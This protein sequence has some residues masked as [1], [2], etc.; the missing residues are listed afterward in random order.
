M[1]VWVPESVFGEV[2]LRRRLALGSA[3]PTTVS[4]GIRVATTEDRGYERGER[5]L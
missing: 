2:L 5:E 3:S 1:A 4:S